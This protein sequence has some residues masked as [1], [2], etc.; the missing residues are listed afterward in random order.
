M[1]RTSRPRCFVGAVKKNINDDSDPG[2]CS[3]NEKRTDEKW[4]AVQLD[5]Y[6]GGIETFNCVGN[7][8][9][10]GGSVLLQIGKIRMPAIEV[11]YF[12]PEPQNYPRAS[13][14]CQGFPGGKIFDDVQQRKFAL[15]DIWRGLIPCMAKHQSAKFLMG[16]TDEDKDG[17]WI[18][19]IGKN[20]TSFLE[21]HTKWTEAGAMALGVTGE[22]AACD[23]STGDKCLFHKIEPAQLECF[24]CWYE[25][26][27]ITEYAHLR[28]I[29]QF[30][31]NIL[32]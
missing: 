11:P 12:S 15:K 13:Q 31:S 9:A 24:A 25:T 5:I 2:T 14:I 3:I 4:K 8:S 7:N 27:L 19:C 26:E 6:V 23:C 17:K 1:K 29:A 28:T 30:A 10:H 32:N 22:V 20:V 21:W 18:D 16:I